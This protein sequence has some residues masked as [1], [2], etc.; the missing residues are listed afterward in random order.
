M[1]KAIYTTPKGLLKIKE[2]PM[3][4]AKVKGVYAWIKPI[5]SKGEAVKTRLE[6]LKEIK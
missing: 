5:G 4:V 2:Q 3:E 6:Y 1:K